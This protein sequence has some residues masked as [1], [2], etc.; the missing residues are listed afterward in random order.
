MVLSEHGLPARF[1]NSRAFDLD[2]PCVKVTTLHAAKGLEFSIVVVAH[3]EAGRLPRPTMATDAEELAAYEQG[4][5]R[6]FYVGCT[7]AM[8]H[9]FV[10]YER[11]LPSPFVA[12]MTAEHWQG[13]G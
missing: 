3:V 7:R 5:R 10:T 13:V 2:E 1:M 6:L 8:R 11:D 12:D 4:Q 9:L